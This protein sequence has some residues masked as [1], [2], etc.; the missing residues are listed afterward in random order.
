M[1]QTL[2][3]AD[4]LKDRLENGADTG[5]ASVGAWV[6]V[7]C[8]FVL[9]D[10]EAGQSLYA[11]GHIPTAR[12]ADLDRD[13]SAA[14]SD[15]TGR[16]PLPS[17]DDW[18]ARLNAWGIHNDSIVVAYDQK[19]GALAARFWWLMRWIGH[20]QVFV[21]DGGM[22]A[23]QRAGYAIATEAPEIEIADYSPHVQHHLWVSTT[24]VEE[25]IGQ[26]SSAR[27]VVD[28]RSAARYRGDEEPIDPV[29]GHIPTAINLP[30][31]E[32]VDE[33]GYF[34]PAES[35]R[36][37]FSVLAEHP[38]DVI[39]T[40][41]SGVTACHNLLAMEHAGLTGSKLYVGSWSEWIR[42]PNRP[43]ATG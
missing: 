2:I 28:A 1:T 42:Q 14:V 5:E 9:S 17:V 6:V 7:D 29:A 27:V 34:L 26:T 11:E 41:G 25:A 12:Y 15:M 35:L 33:D 23:W 13:M 16:H 24:D 3:R 40:C 19:A 32:N 21:L 31:M 22:E 39:H 30:F 36:R 4:E 10:P 37:R 43:V 8:R 18:V 20:E 38:T